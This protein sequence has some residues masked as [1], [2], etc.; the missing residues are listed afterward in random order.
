MESN[1]AR[2]KIHISEQTAAYLMDAGKDDWFIPRADKIVAKGKLCRI[3]YLQYGAHLEGKSTQ[4]LKIFSNIGKGELQ[5]YWLHTRKCSRQMSDLSQNE[6]S[7]DVGDWLD[8]PTELFNSQ[9]DLGFST[10]A[11]RQTLSEQNQRLADWNSNQLLQLLDNVVAHRKAA[12]KVA[13]VSSTSS[14]ENGQDAPAFGAAHLGVGDDSNIVK[15]AKDVIV[16]PPYDA[17]VFVKAQETPANLSEVVQQQLHDYV[18]I[19]CSMYVDNPFHSYQHAS[20]VTMSIIKILTSLAAPHHN[21]L[22]DRNKDAN[23]DEGERAR[24]HAK[25]FGISSD[26]VTHF[27]LAFA[28]LIHDVDHP[29]VTNV[30]LVKENKRLARIFQGRCIAE[31]NSFQ[32]AWDLLMDPSFDYLRQAIY[33]TKEEFHHFRDLAINAVLATDIFDKELNEDRQRRWHLAFPEDES[34]PEEAQLKACEKE[35]SDRR[36]TV[37]LEY[38]VQASDVAHTMQHWHVY[39]KWNDRLF[40]ESLK[41][42]KA[43]RLEEDPCEFW[44]ERELEFFDNIIIPMA[45]KLKGCGAFGIYF[46]EYLNYATQNRQEWE[47]KGR[48]IVGEMEAKFETLAMG[49]MS[50][51]S[52]TEGSSQE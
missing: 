2:E 42:H 50:G 39:R 26:P 37:V 14:T 23:R 27:A 21:N 18:S 5:T 12:L 36:A 16:M 17:E 51:R 30:Q 41:S 10:N 3:L 43:G 13:G 8:L 4:S 25:T 44:Y 34:T 32:C 46:D 1:G 48:E 40:H 6:D 7:F 22:K 28:T 33:T 47:R 38:V 24:H 35:L 15:E 9:H 52:E 49:S 11:I 31:Q 45:K 19:I 20:H 29:G